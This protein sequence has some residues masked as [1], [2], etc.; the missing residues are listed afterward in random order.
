MWLAYEY[1]QDPFYKDSAEAYLANFKNRLERHVALDH[2]DIGFLYSLSA[3]AEWRVTGSTE[4][5]EVAL[6]AVITSYSIHYTKLYELTVIMSSSRC[7]RRSI[8][9]GTTPG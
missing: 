6:Q 7:R 4:A 1:G 8:R 3:V 2:H 5:R 9:L